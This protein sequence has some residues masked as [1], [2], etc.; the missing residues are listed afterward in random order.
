MTHSRC[1]RYVTHVYEIWRWARACRVCNR[2]Y[3]RV[4]TFARSRD[5]QT[6]R[7]ETQISLSEKWK[8]MRDEGEGE[9][10]M[11]GKGVK[12]RRRRR[13]S[14]V[15]VNGESAM[16]IVRDVLAKT[17]YKRDARR[18]RDARRS[19]SL[20]RH[21]DVPLSPR[22]LSSSFFSFLLSTQPF[23]SFSLLFLVRLRSFS[24]RDADV[25]VDLLLSFRTRELRLLHEMKTVDSLLSASLTRHVVTPE[26]LPGVLIAS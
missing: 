17:R 18:R 8:K 16:W 24:R 21:D 20:R 1:T 22:I 6:I 4:W 9:E 25:R 11:K 12:T 5:N 3:R 19:P 15:R 23:L 2:V 14:A 13:F 7:V 10:G 26:R